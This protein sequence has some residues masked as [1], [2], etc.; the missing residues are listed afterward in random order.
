VGKKDSTGA[1]SFLCDGASPGAPVLSD[2]YATYNPGL[3]ENRGG[4][5]SAGGQT[6]YY[7]FDRLGNLWLNDAAAG[8]S[9]TYYQDTDGFG[10]LTAA[11][12][13]AL[14]PFRYG[15]A[16][17]CQTDADT[18]LVL[19][20][21][22]YYDSRIGRFISQDPAGDG[23]NWYEYA[24]NS[25]TNK[26]DPTG[27]Q[28][29]IAGPGGLSPFEQMVVGG[30]GSLQ[31]T[32][33]LLDD[34]AYDE[35]LQKQ[36]DQANAIG[37]ALL[38]VAALAETQIL[39]GVGLTGGAQADAGLMAG[40]GA[41]AGVAAGIFVGKGGALSAGTSAN[42]GYLVPTALNNKDFSWGASASAGA[43]FFFTNANTMNDTRRTQK[44]LSFNI[45][46]G[47]DLGISLSY[48]QGIW[49]FGIT[50]IGVGEGISVSQ[51]GTK[52]VTSSGIRHR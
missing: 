34:N 24:G 43:G 52:T 39:W 28:A 48:G 8:K 44:T 4:A 26:T 45:G 46:F 30:A 3:S 20:G 27:Q 33:D 14:T 40:L 1:Y 22:R 12:G 41:Q 16:N 31:W 38:G 36:V 15:G 13:S 51:Y 5:P 2:G 50:P 21:H 17:G 9:Q 32:Q 23:T 19:M 49:A 11:G 35:M 37:S 29:V 7:S 18:G 47:I 42:A 10:S 25:P 6:L